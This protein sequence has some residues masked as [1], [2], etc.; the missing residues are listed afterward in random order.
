MKRMKHYI[1]SIKNGDVFFDSTFKL[2]IVIQEVGIL[3]LLFS[4]LF[5]V[6]DSRDLG[7][8]NAVV[9]VMYFAFKI[10][11]DKKKFKM[12][13]NITVAEVILNGILTTIFVGSKPGFVFYYFS[14]I[15]GVS[16]FVL[17]WEE[18]RQKEK[19]TVIYASVLVLATI[20]VFFTDMYCEPIR[21]MDSTEMIIFSVL[22][23]VM[24]FVAACEFLI[25]LQW[26][27]THKSEIM[28]SIN[29]ELDEIANLDPLTEL[30]NRRFMNQKLEDKLN[31]LN[32]QGTIFGI[33]MG[34]IDNFKRVN[35]TYGH[36]VGDEV[37]KMV[38]GALKKSTRDD[39]FVSRWG[40]EEFLI[41]I[42]GNKRIT[43][44]VA[45]RMRQLIKE[46]PIVSGK[47]EINVTMTFGVSES[48]PGYSIDKL[49]E[50]ADENLY[51]GKSEG[52]DRVVS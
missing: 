34:D 10:L 12:I 35:D 37:L 23:I 51:K 22:N 7:L 15:C 36:D 4:L 29:T 26:D 39:D 27:Y 30:Y 25:F 3:H 38:A 2:S 33:I 31:E 13:I 40:G 24:A 50:I 5:F 44:D 47:A 45:Q 9:C 42:N 49:I 48:I 43:V 19:Y 28:S 52:K 11:V 41:V 21:K 18:F 1:D 14:L 16:Y 46:T 20:T 6:F 8:Y 32:K 17:T